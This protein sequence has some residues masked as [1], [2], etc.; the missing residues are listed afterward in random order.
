MVRNVFDMRVL[1][2]ASL[3]ILSIRVQRFLQ[4]YTTSE[5]VPAKLIS[6]LNTDMIVMNKVRAFC[7][8]NGLITRDLI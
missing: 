5:K 4:A 3:S 8:L 6:K 2:L 7:K 1:L